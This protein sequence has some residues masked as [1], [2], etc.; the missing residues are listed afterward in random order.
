M[1]LVNYWWLCQ[2]L[3]VSFA[4][5]IVVAEVESCIISSDA[6]CDSQLICHIKKLFNKL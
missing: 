4:I 3:E 5:I 6:S 2:D 1:T